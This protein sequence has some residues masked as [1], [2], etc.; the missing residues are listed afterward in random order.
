MFLRMPFGLEMSQSIFQR[1]TDRTYERHMEAV[2]IAD[3]I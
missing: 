1:R 2:G 3:G